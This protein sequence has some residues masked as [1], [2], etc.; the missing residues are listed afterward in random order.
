MIAKT[1]FPSQTLLQSRQMTKSLWWLIPWGWMADAGIAGVCGLLVR[2]R[3]GFWS[4]QVLSTGALSFC[5]NDTW[6][7]SFSARINT[8]GLKVLRTSGV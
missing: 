3:S 2:T 6:A 7:R 4:L 1:L 8:E 5:H